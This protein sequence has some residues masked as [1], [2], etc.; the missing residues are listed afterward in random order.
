MNCLFKFKGNLDEC[1][2]KFVE[3]KWEI[4]YCLLFKIK[5]DI[6]MKVGNYL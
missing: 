1:I 3:K 2:G 5:D 4:F 6:Y